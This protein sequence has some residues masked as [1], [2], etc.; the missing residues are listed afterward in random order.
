MLNYNDLQYQSCTVVKIDLMTACVR[1]I[2][3]SA[4]NSL[5]VL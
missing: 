1:V 3:M 5:G 2:L 4:H